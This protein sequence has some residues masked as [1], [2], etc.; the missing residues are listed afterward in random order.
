MPK[1]SILGTGWGLRAQ[2][3]AFKA[4]GWTL[5]ALWGRSREKVAAAQ[6]EHAFRH[7][8]ANWK[9]AIGGADLVSVTTPPAEH[10]EQAAAVLSAS[11]HL[12]CEKPLTLDAAQARELL[13][14]SRVTR[15][16]GLVD[17]ELRMLPARQRMRELVRDGYIG[18]LW[19]VECRYASDTRA[20]PGARHNWWSS[21]EQ[22]GGV[23]GAVGSH[24]LDGL[25]FVLER[26]ISIAAA[27][28]A[29]AFPTRRDAIGY[30]QA[31]TSDDYASV[32]AEVGGAP[33]SI[34]LNAAARQ[35]QA[36]LVILRGT[37]GTLVL[38]GNLKLEGAQ[39]NDRV[40]SDLT[41]PVPEGVPAAF[42]A[43]PWRLGTY[44]L[45]VRLREAVE[46]GQAPADVATLA[47]GVRV[48]ELLDDARRL[49]DWT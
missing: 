39:G 3:P 31:V 18:D 8:P 32:L 7:T 41:P 33:A 2:A 25:L 37:K 20:D 35:A 44:L 15:A 23:W 13:A 27:R 22:G 29:T 24:V 1:L 42:R 28:F 5:H 19:S 21:R 11:T 14:A 10:L 45:A 26:D 6:H 36:D 4:A 46:S 48:Q 16:L 17:F 38:R 43:D 30:Q 49:G 12:L 47:D 9:D 40:L 34:V